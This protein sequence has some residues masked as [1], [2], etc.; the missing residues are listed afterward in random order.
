M[1]ASAPSPEPT[2]RAKSQVPIPTVTD[3]YL[4]TARADLP[5]DQLPIPRGAAKV[6]VRLLRMSDGDPAKAAVI[7][8]H[9]AGGTDDP[10]FALLAGLLEECVD[11]PLIAGQEGKAG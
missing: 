2:R 8:R 3:P 5:R 4:P 11:D 10:R 1:T 7:A 6:L 9:W